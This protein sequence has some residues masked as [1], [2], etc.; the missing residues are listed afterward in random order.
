MNRP[1]YP[2][3]CVLPSSC[4]SQIREN[5]GV[6]DIDPVKY[7]RHQKEWSFDACMERGCLPTG[8]PIE[9]KFGVGPWSEL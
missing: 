3:G 5:Q 4:I 8:E 9:G 2:I 7:E 6:Y 1:C